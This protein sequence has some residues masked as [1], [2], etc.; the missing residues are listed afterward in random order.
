M[1]YISL[2]GSWENEFGS[3]MQ[4]SSVDP[5]TGIFTGKYSSTTGATGTYLLTGITDTMVKIKATVTIS[6]DKMLVDFAG[7]SPATKGPS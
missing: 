4:I 1:D 3:S 7:S 2:E 5:R 6:D